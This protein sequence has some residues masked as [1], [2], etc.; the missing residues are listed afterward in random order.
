MKKLLLFII[1][2]IFCTS[3][4]AQTPLTTAVDFTVT[5]VDGQSFNL[6]DT[7]AENKYVVIDFFYY[8]CVPCQQTAPKVNS[9]Y[10]YFGCNTSNVFFLGIDKNDNTAKTILFGDN[11]GAHYPAVS[12]LDGGGSAVNTAFGIPAYPTI[13]LIAPDHSIIN[14]DIWP[15]ADAAYLYNYIQ[16]RGGVPK[17]CPSIGVDEFT[18]NT[19]L[20]LLIMPNPTSGQSDI[21]FSTKKGVS[22]EIRI[23]DLLGKEVFHHSFTPAEGDHVSYNIQSGILAAGTYM[24]KIFEDNQA[25]AVQKLSVIK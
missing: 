6:F 13:I 20:H 23:F 25:V 8:A 7:L 11:F 4:K 16:S 14:S 2:L 5:T 3:L 1:I 21:D 17:S 9:A 12:G 18:S 22:Y 10:E 15:I 19:D 24:V